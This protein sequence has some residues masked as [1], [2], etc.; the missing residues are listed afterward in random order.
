MDAKQQSQQFSSYKRS[1]KRAWVA[2]KADLVSLLGNI[3]TKLSTY[4]L[5]DYDPPAG[6]SLANLDLEWKTLLQDENRR[7]ILINEKIRE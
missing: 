6:L 7:S 2:E 5:K 1:L 4:R 3:K